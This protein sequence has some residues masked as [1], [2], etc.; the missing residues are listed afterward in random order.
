MNSLTVNLHLMMTSFYRPTAKRHKIVIERGAFP[1]DRYAVESQLRLH[2]LDPDESLM[3]LA[4]SA[5]Q[6]YIEESDIE[7]LL[8]AEGTSIALLLLPGVQYYS[9]QAFDMARLTRAGHK[10]GCLVAFDLAHAAG[11]LPLK[12]HDWGVDFAVW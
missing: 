9:G 6:A 4:P 3:E 11:N 10:A 5:G 8:E 7:A 1:S 2:G 12:L